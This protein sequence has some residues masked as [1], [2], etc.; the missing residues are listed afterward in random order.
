MTTYLNGVPIAVAPVAHE[1]T[2]VSG[3]ADDIDSALAAVAVPAHM[4]KGKLAFTLNKLLQGA[5]A[6][7]DP[8]EV[9]VPSTL[10]SEA[11]VALFQTNAGVGDMQFPSNLNDNDTGSY[12]RAN[13]VD[14]YDEVDFGRVVRIKRWRQFGNT[15]N[16]GDGAWKIQY[17]DLS[18]YTW[19]DWATGIA[20]RATADWSNLAT[21]TEAFTDK[22]RLVCTAVDSGISNSLINEL[23]VIY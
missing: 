17:Y 12:A 7:V 4:D 23:E 15:T 14:E 19:A 9:D 13:S 1:A 20:T 8:T 2:H 21:E 11:T 18:T 6:G 3:G 16:N 5:G 10:A 22:I